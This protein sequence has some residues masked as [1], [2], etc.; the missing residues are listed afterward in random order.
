MSTRSRGGAARPAAREGARD[1]RWEIALL[2]LALAGL[3]LQLL[4]NPKL[5]DPKDRAAM[6]GAVRAILGLSLMMA[7]RHGLK[8]GRALLA[9]LRGT[10]WRDHAALVARV[11]EGKASPD[12]LPD[13]E[14]PEARRIA[15]AIGR[16]MRRQA[17]RRACG[18]RPGAGGTV[19]IRPVCG[20]ESVRA[21]GGG[22]ASALGGARREKW[23]CAPG[24]QH[25]HIV[26]IS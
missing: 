19:F 3:G 17:R 10:A 20:P 13:L 8:A 2:L 12:L 4:A 18:R 1:P 15:D 16:W 23:P 24:S 6:Q 26:T 9:V 25:A 22:G 11:G 21:S 5:R 14:T 7:F